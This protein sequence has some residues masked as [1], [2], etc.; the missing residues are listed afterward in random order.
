MMRRAR[1]RENRSTRLT[2]ILDRAPTAAERRRWSSSVATTSEALRRSLGLRR[3]PVALEAEPGGALVLSVADVTGHLVACGIEWEIIPKFVADPFQPWQRSLL[4]MLHRARGERF[5]LTPHVEN[6]QQRTAFIDA[7]AMAWCDAL[8]RALRH[9]PIQQYRSVPLETPVLQGRLDLNTQLRTVFTRPGRL[10]CHV[11]RLDVDNDFNRL[12]HWV[13]TRLVTQVRGGRA[14][15]RVGD[16][17]L[18]LPTVSGT[19]GS[20]G[21]LRRRLP[22]QFAHFAEAWTLSR[23]LARGQGLVA[24]GAGIV[25]R[26]VVFALPPLF[27]QFVDVSLREVARRL[28]A[29]WC[30]RR[31]ASRVF[32]V[33]RTAGVRNYYARPDNVLARDGSPQVVLDAKYK[34]LA[35]A[36]LTR[37]RRPQNSDVY[38]LAAA[39]V[40]HDCQRGLLIYPRIAGDPLGDEH[41]RRWTIDFAG[42]RLHVG[43][44]ALPV[45][46]LTN[47]AEVAAFD[48]TLTEHVRAMIALDIASA[49]G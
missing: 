37:L 19:S 7:V 43:A 8:D 24:G 22:R 6:E 44:V 48:T 41:L 30:S 14:R 10:Q 34:T 11:D 4:T 20:P 1:I 21:L 13:G 31:Q 28:G 27:E 29:G 12:F 38:Q 47:A 35:D 26:G 5:E 46:R 17:L 49:L 9:A 18:R 42:R 2:D 16:T 39:L 33:G 40:A 3:Q 45:E 15:R 23:L 25:G 32:A 36:E